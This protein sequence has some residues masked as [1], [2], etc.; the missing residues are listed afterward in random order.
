MSA[1]IPHIIPHRRERIT[2]FLTHLICIGILFIL[3]EVLMG[4]GSP[5]NGPVPWGFYAKSLV[6]IGV[7]YVNYYFVINQWAGRKRNVG[8]FIACNTALIAVSLLITYLI[9]R[10]GMWP[11]HDERPFPSLNQTIGFLSRDMAM[12]ILTM[13]LSVALKLSDRWQRLEQRRQMLA[14]AHREQELQQLKSQLNP[15]FLFNSLNT[16]YALISISPTQAQ[17]A[18]HTLSHMLRYAL[19]DSSDNV[20]LRQ[21][22]DFINDYI[23]LIALRIGNRPGLEVTLDTGGHDDLMIPPMLFISLVENVFKHGNTGHADDI[24]RISLTIEDST[25]HFRTKNRFDTAKEQSSASGI[26]IAN[27]RRRLK[28]L[29]GDSASLQCNTCDDIYTVDLTIKLTK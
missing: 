29:Y 21:E 28:L 13:G 1:E 14:A 16:I 17:N 26:G 23:R 4:I 5:H 19:Y 15:H 12:I 9:S 27:I 24:F 20:T 6:Y 2:Q 25:L 11:H 3:P 10:Y 18:V 8:R 22:V 7:F